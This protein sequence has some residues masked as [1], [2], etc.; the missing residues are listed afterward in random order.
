M[1][2][3]MASWPKGQ[4]FG[5]TD[6]RGKGDE[7]EAIVGGNQLPPIS[8]NPDILAMVRKDWLAASTPQYTIGNSSVVVPRAQRTGVCP[9]GVIHVVVP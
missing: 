4:L 9:E 5:Q 2:R 7:L 6:S 8:S 1:A 3:F